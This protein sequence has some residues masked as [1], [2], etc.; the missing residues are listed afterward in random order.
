MGEILVFHGGVPIQFDKPYELK[1]LE[2]I[3][4]TRQQQKIIPPVGDEVQPWFDFLWSYERGPTMASFMDVN[5]VKVI[6]CSHTATTSFIISTF[7]QNE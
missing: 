6:V 2:S 7:I 5:Q 3:N 4:P 1:Q